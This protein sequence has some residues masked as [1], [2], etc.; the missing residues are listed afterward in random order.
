LIRAGLILNPRSRRH[1][2]GGLAE[3]PAR[4]GLL[5]AAPTTRDE[6]R[7]ALARF[8][9]AEVSVL[10]VDGGDGTVREVLTHAAEPFGA[11]LPALAVLPSGKTNALALDLGAPRGWSLD[12]ALAAARRGRTHGRR[13]IEV[14]RA[15]DPAPLAR[16][17]IFGAGAFVRA[18]E[19]AQRTHRLGALDDLA[20]GLTLA[21][22]L[23]QTVFG[24]SSSSWRRGELMRLR[25]DDQ[26]AEQTRLSLVIA[27]TLERLPL[28]LKP[29]GPAAGG[30]RMLTVPAPPRRL[31]GALPG[32]L[33]GR[34]EHRLAAGG[35]RRLRPE[36]FELSLPSGFVLD[37]EAFPGGD[38]TVRSGAPLAFV[39]P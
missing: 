33:L 12:A 39:A 31:L 18:T 6:L 20:I 16:G 29:F 3:L 5:S 13:P 8:A 35:Y 17:F 23:T 2:A 38:L 24:G 37:G 15:G 7:T 27:S 14:F 4:E 11:R 21:A 19:L 32:L 30:L 22:A 26:E 9:A 1:R 28:N 25:I 36:S 34:D 10:V